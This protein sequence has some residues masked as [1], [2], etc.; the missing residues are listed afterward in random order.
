MEGRVLIHTPRG[1]DAAVVQKVLAGRDLVALVCES[2][3]EMLTNLDE[4]AATAILTEESLLQVPEMP[5]SAWLTA[6]P[7]WSDFP[8]I[9]LASRD[10][11]G[12]SRRALAL[13]QKLGNVF[14]LERPV[15][16]E[17]LARAADAAVRARRRQY[18][19]RLNLQ[20]L[21]D[22]RA[23]VERLNGALE[24]RIVSRTRELAGANDRLM[25]EIAERERAQAALIQ[26]QKMEAIGRLTGG[27][28]HDFNNLLHVV[29]MNLDMVSRVAK[30]DKVLG[31]AARAKGAV[32]R[33]AK[34]TGQLLSFA[35]N[36]S[37]LPRLTD[38]NALLEGLRELVAVSV[39]PSVNVELQ[40]ADEPVWAVLDA[41]QLEMA[42][43]NLA[44]NA[45]D[46]MPGG[47]ALTICASVAHMAS[48]ADGR[49]AGHGADPVGA[50]L[51]PGPY[52]AVSVVDTGAGIP[53]HL[54]TKVFDPFFTT[55]PVGSGTGLGLSQVYGFAQQSGGIA[56]VRS[57][58]GR[59]TVV[60]MRFPASN[61]RVQAGASNA[62]IPTP[63]VAAE[64]QR[65]L[66]IED[67]AE[68]R[69]AIVDSLT[70]LGYAVSE[71]AG[72]ASGLAALGAAPQDLL[73]VD[74]AMPGMN[75]AEVIARARE[76]AGDIPVILATGY[77]DMAE[78]GRVLGTQSI[79]IKPFDISTLATAVS[80]ALQP[81][82]VA[83]TEHS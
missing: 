69:R 70:M 49:D 41:N 10:A 52:V 54:L 46:A 31:I 78:V 20:Q 12:R 29:N 44:V 9:V 51:K 24:E 43:L 19:T 2:A 62:A 3:E 81:A 72:G 11:N 23:E 13:L 30:D 63:D 67:D 56:T 18:A 17:T 25:A 1:R 36:Q 83:P 77:A 7:S 53:P 60:E 8:F 40:L 55:K 48:S 65:V 34:L 4:G 21:Q 66:V 27:I 45:R 61:D 39:G 28:A 57:E 80:K 59:G 42:V 32:G 75:G 79:L 6:Q 73:I 38:V 33:G 15:H 26:V 37:L 76:Q 22:T 35:R 64:R 74:Y 71:A 58:E 16:S 5:L 68:V 82:L 14:V 50:L 47:G